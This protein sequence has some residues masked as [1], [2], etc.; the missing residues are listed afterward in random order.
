MDMKLELIP[1]PVK[2]VD[3]AKAFYAERLGFRVDVDVQPMEGVRVVQLTPPGSGCSIGMGTGLAAYD[4]EPGSIHALHLVVADLEKARDELISRGI[5]VGEVMDHGG[6]VKSAGFADLD[7]NT[8][9]LQQMAW[10]TGD[11]F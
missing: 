10:R 3:S 11:A 5:D 7:G 9:E 1:L 8:L 4:G 6:G 2:D